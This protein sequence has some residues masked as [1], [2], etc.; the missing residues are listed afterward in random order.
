MREAVKLRNAMGH[1]SLV[2]GLATCPRL[3]VGAAIFSPDWQLLATG[4]NGMPRGEAHCEDVGC[5]LD[6]GHCLSIHAE[7]NALLQG[8]R[9]GVRLQGGT[10]FTTHCPCHRCAGLII[11]VG[12]A[13]VYYVDVYPSIHYALASM[14]RL[15]AA[16]I[17]VI[18]LEN[19]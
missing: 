6:G 17:R 9:T 16:N 2:A 1:A 13:A 8:A 18:R 14:A 15:E 4:R 12:L 19:P 11:N 3:R 5:Q 10:M 7:E